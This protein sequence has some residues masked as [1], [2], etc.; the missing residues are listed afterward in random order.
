MENFVII[1]ILQNKYSMNDISAKEKYFA[2][3]KK[4]I[5]IET[6]CIFL[7]LDKFYIKL[8]IKRFQLNWWKSR[9]HNSISLDKVS[10]LD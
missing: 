1:K 5:I 6:R 7:L 9:R 2:Q 3:I 4:R 8:I 10:L